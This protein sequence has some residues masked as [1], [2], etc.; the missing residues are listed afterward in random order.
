MGLVQLAANAGT[1]PNV[2]FIITDDQERSEFNFLPEGRDER[3]EPRN[4]TPNIDRL[5]TEG[6]VFLN[7]YVSSPV[8]TPSRYSVLT[9]T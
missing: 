8:C 2:L 3:G 9:G 7:Q 1:K 6:V 5:A 4:L